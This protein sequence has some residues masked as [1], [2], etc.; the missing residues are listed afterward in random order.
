[1]LAGTATGEN[2]RGLQEGSLCGWHY[3]FHCQVVL[4][5]VNSKTSRQSAGENKMPHDLLT[6]VRRVPRLTFMA[7]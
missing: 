2:D 5:I 4:K 7:R 1:M 3:P 6:P